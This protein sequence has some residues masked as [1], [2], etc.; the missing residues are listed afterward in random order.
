M[1]RERKFSDALTFAKGPTRGPQPSNWESTVSRATE[2]S[3][4]TYVFRFGKKDIWKI[5]WAT[6]VKARLAQVNE[7]VPSEL[8]GE[9][10]VE[11]FK[12][13]RPNQQEAYEMEQRLLELLAKHRYPRVSSRNILQETAANRDRRDLL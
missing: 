8:L 3:A 13:P 1:Q 11:G 4:Y 5:G 10:W 9:S 12:E 6:D 7:H 2:G